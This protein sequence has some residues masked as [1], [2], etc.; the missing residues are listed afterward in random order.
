MCFQLLPPLTRL[1]AS[2][3]CQLFSH[4]YNLHTTFMRYF[5]QTL[6]VMFFEVVKETEAVFLTTASCFCKLHV[7]LI[8]FQSQWYDGKFCLGPW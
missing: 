6:S 3:C 5:T 8:R 4:C 7:A 2:I 1:C